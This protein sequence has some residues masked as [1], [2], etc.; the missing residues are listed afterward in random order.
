MKRFK[1]LFSLDEFKTFFKNIRTACGTDS[2]SNYLLWNDYTEQEL[3]DLS[4]QF[5]LGEVSKCPSF[6]C[7]YCKEQENLTPIINTIK[8]RYFLNWRAIEQAYFK[9][10]YKPLEN[11]SMLEERTPD[12]KETIDTENNAKSENKTSTSVYG[13]NSSEA[14][15]TS[16]ADSDTE[17]LKA[18]N[19][20]K[21]TRSNTGK[22]TL[23]R[24]G[25][26]GVTTSQQMLESELKLRKFDYWHDI[27]EGCS[28][29]L[30]L[31][32]Y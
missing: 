25:N 24:S 22:E 23:T 14:V 28:K 13:F 18:N 21:S 15:P 11:Y 12:L 8:T 31:G 4:I 1:D 2:D 6:L 27:F 29:I 7:V 32:I 20:G 19:F 30:C 17:S 5:Y 10:N 9:T 3:E 16:E 26:I